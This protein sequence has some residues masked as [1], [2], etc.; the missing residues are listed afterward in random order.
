MNI[1]YLHEDPK[2]CA[3]QHLDKHVVKMLIEY[4]QLMSTAHRMLDGVMYQGKTKAGRNIKRYRLQNTNERRGNSSTRRV[5]TIIRVQYGFETTP[6]TTTGYIR[7][8]HTY[9]MNLN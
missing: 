1:F 3:E 4:A 9:M 8:G 5:I 2:T 7:C 6:T